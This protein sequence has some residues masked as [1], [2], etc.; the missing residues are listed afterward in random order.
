MSYSPFPNRVLSAKK[1]DDKYTLLMARAIYYTYDSNIATICRRDSEKFAENFLYADGNQSTEKYK[2]Y[3]AL[4]NSGKSFE[5]KGLGNLDYSIVPFAPNFINSAIELMSDKTN[6]TNV[7]F[8]NDFS[9]KERIKKKNQMRADIATRP[10]KQ[11][12][13]KMLGTKTPI[14]PKLPEKE[15][16]VDILEEVGGIKLPLETALETGIDYVLNYD[17]EWEKTY[18]RDV[19][20]NLLTTGFAIAVEFVNPET[21]L[22]DIRLPNLLN[23]VLDGSTKNN[24]DDVQYFG[25]IRKMTILDVYNQ[26]K[27]TTNTILTEED[28]KELGMN[29]D[30]SLSNDYDP[31]YFSLPKEQW[32]QGYY[33]N[34]VNVLDFL[35]KSVDIID[36][37]VRHGEKVY[38]K[39]KIRKSEI[40]SGKIKQD[41]GGYYKII[42]KK[43]SKLEVTVWRRGKWLID[44]DVV[45][46]YG[47]VYQ[48]VRDAKYDTS[49]PIHAYKLS[50][51]SLISIIK[52]NLDALQFDMLK[53]QSLKYEATG[54]GLAID[55]DAL[56]NIK[57]GGKDY[58][59]K[60]L[61][62]MYKLKNV[63]LVKTKRSS[64]PNDRMSNMPIKEIQGGIGNYFNELLTDIQFHINQMQRNTGLNDVALAQTPNPEVTLGQ[65][66]QAMSASNNSLGHIYEAYK[67]IKESV[68]FSIAL[69]LNNIAKSNSK[70][71]YK[72]ILGDNLWKA[73]KVDNNNLILRK[74]IRIIDNPSKEEI[75]ML[76][77]NMQ[78]IAPNTL[79]GYD[80]FL[81]ESMISEG[82]PLKAISA[83]M[84]N[85]IRK[86]EE[87]ASKNNEMM[88]KQNA[89]QQQAIQQQKLQAE[90]AKEQ[91]KLQADSTL[92]SQEHNQKLDEMQQEYDLKMRNERDNDETEARLNKEFTHDNN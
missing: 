26:V 70:S 72:D 71:Q 39:G 55:Y 14:D 64:D 47:L 54:Y 44:T 1:K 63:L 10:L 2:D 24:F 74:G 88:M 40:K 49:N 48:Q 13:D 29:Y 37:P 66:Q 16:D 35:Y 17:I 53:I 90:Q 81:I 34:K 33:P 73:L 30:N 69:R 77:A 18:A 65:S 62:K 20:R 22:I 82:K 80:M 38:I 9:H 43:P 89:E 60:K 6:R 28:I 92:S 58:D 68:A 79:S 84:E 8:L 15:E 5:R 56:S 3:F 52:P 51:K 36:S 46:D 12:I 61:I 7:V 76:F 67:S 11:N 86:R 87:E 50:S 78:R 45:F 31:N 19:K 25:E 4:E 21:G 32:I 42:N 91:F 41:K 75:Q 59:V 57:M 85:K 23:I 27:A 83:I